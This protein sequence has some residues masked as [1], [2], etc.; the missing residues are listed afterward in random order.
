MPQKTSSCLRA[1]GY[2]K[3]DERT[4]REDDYA[5]ARTRALGHKHGGRLER[6]Y[7]VATHFAQVI[8][9]RNR[10]QEP[11]LERAFQENVEKWKDETGH[12]SSLTKALSH[13]SYLRIIGLAK[14]S[15]DHQLEKLLL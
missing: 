12:L 1:R 14:Y 10:S 6:G 11:D 2:M 7:E 8:A 4:M 13:P 5:Y 9:A 15:T 3:M